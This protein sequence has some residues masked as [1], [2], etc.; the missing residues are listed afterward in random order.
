MKIPIYR[1]LLVAGLAAAMAG[2]GSSAP[3]IVSTPI[4]NIDEIPLKVSELTDVQLQGWGGAD[5]IS[6]TIPGMSVKKAYNEIIKNNKGKKV[7]VAVIDSGVD[8]EHEDLDGVIWTNPNERPNNGIDDDKNGYVDD[9]HGWNFLGDAVKENLEYTRILKKLR[10]KFNGVPA[11]AVKPE[12]QQEFELYQRAKAEYDKEYNEAMGL[13][14][15]YEGIVQQLKVSHEA[16]SKQLGKENYTVDELREMQATTEEMQQY[17]GFL[18]QVMSNVEGTIPEA[19]TQLQ[20]AISYFDGR[21]ATHFNLD[22]DGRAVVGD[23]VDDITDTNYGNNNVMGPTPDKEDL[24]HGTHVAGIIAAER[25]NNTGIDGVANNVEIMVLRAVPDGDEYDK[26]IA[27][28]IRY[29]VDNGASIINTS[30]GK[31]FSTH[32]E[33]VRDA[34]KY[35]DK[36]DVLIVNAAGNE[37]INLDQNAVYPNDQDPKNPQEISEN[38][39]TVGALNYKY[40]SGLIAGFS[41]FGKTNVDVFAPGTKIWSTTP[42]NEY[43]YLQGTSMAAPAVA[44]I[45]AM[46]RSYFPKLSDY[47]VKRV[48][49]ESGLS[50]NATVIIGGEPSNTKRFSELSTSGKMANLYNAL[51]MADKISN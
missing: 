29:A 33:W 32:P 36:N 39:L 51:I 45:A 2:C 8:I 24:K 44:G 41:N 30:F 26:D 4:E 27:L 21:L 6:D 38:F 49:M 50:T 28:A 15:Q 35:A 31:Y 17:K 34:I 23:D 40:G 10:P 14:N 13:K 43:E 12:D 18:I 20:E 7:I 37:G 9:M 46:I 3:A 47:E 5:L 16:V 11:G 1:P 42:N 25:N 22:L 19:I 48:I